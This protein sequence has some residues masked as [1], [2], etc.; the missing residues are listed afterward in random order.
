MGSLG[1]C[2]L[3]LF[4]DLGQN[5]VRLRRVARSTHRASDEGFLALEPTANYTWPRQRDRPRAETAPGPQTILT[6]PYIF[7]RRPHAR[8]RRSHRIVVR[9]TSTCRSAR[10]VLAP[11]VG[12]LSR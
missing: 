4:D 2:D 7:D 10:G 6:G 5:F 1:D 12:F 9:A 11:M 8:L 3:S